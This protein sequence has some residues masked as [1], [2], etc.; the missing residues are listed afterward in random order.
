MSL[1]WIF[2]TKGIVLSA[3]STRFFSCSMSAFRQ[4]IRE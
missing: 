4:E 3:A 2:C 1:W